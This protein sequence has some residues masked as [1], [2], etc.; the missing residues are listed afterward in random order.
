MPDPAWS[1]TDNWEAEYD[2]I[3]QSISMVYTVY[4]SALAFGK[5]A[6]MGERSYR[7]GDPQ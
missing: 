4:S 3:N 6:G 7:L 1:V 5:R 2:S